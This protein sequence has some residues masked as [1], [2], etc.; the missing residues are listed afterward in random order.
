MLLQVCS[1]H[2]IQSGVVR[3]LTSKLVGGLDLSPIAR[4]ILTRP[5]LVAPGRALSQAS[6][7]LNLK[8]SLVPRAREGAHLPMLPPRLLVTPVWRAAW[9]G[10][11]PRAS[12]DI[13]GPSKLA[14]FS[15]LEWHPC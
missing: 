9:L 2:S 14:C 5:T 8:I 12:I 15:L 7:A 6:T 1:T 3:P 10:P 4:A 11:S 13:T